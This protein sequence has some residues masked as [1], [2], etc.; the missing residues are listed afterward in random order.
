MFHPQLAHSLKFY[1][2]DDKIKEFIWDLISAGKGGELKN[3]SG[4]S[5]PVPRGRKGKKRK[6]N[7]NFLGEQDRPLD[8]DPDVVLDNGYKRHLHRHSNK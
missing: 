5:A 2:G 3:H 1:K 8:F 4:L 6:E 7:L